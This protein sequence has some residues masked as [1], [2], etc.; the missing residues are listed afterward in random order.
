VYRRFR[1]TFL[2]CLQGVEYAEGEEFLQD[3]GT[4]G[5]RQTLV[6]PAP[7]LV[8]FP[9]GPTEVLPCPTDSHISNHSLACGILNALMMEAEDTSETSRNFYQTTR[10]NMSDDSQNISVDTF[11]YVVVSRGNKR[12]P[13]NRSTFKF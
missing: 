13:S 7:N 9:T 6:V 1:E 2:L 10:C 12:A 11:K 4:S 8:P 5:T 3:M